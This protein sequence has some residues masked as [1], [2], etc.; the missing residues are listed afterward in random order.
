MWSCLSFDIC[1][2][3]GTFR[4]QT[5][6]Q[7][8]VWTRHGRILS[9]ANVGC[10]D[11]FEKWQSIPFSFGNKKLAVQ[12]QFWKMGFSISIIS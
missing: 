1:W 3:P 6:M 5:H 8:K 12:Q 11:I 9:V 7:V 10:Q 4:I 2:S